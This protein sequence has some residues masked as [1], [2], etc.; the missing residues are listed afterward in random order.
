[1][2]PVFTFHFYGEKNYTAQQNSSTQLDTHAKSNCHSKK[3]K[4]IFLHVK[5]IK[6]LN[7]PLSTARLNYII[8]VLVD[9]IRLTL[10]FSIQ[11]ILVCPLRK[12]ALLFFFLFS[13]LPTNLIDCLLVSPQTYTHFT[14]S[15]QRE[16][17]NVELHLRAICTLTLCVFLL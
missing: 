17:V 16:V 8:F 3:I 14:A 7:K 6:L 13:E 10:L 12:S 9:L 2:L 1:M 5:M 15:A 11:R 4:Q